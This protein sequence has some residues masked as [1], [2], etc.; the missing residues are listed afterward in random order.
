MVVRTHFI[1]HRIFLRYDVQSL[2]HLL[3]ILVRGCNHIVAV[4][5]DLTIE[6]L[7]ASV[8]QTMLRK[9][10][11]VAVDNLSTLPADRVECHVLIESSMLHTG[12][13]ITHFFCN[14]P[15]ELRKK[16]I[17]RANPANNH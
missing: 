15:T 1:I 12:C 16:F 7:Q 14:V 13:K 10:L 8:L 11:Y 9:G 17:K 5:L 3:I 2:Y 4:F 6:L